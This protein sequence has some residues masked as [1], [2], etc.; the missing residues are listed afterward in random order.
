MIALNGSRAGPNTC[1]SIQ[2][3]EYSH[4]TSKL[5]L[6]LR[7]FQRMVFLA[8]AIFYILVLLSS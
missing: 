1:V 5:H 7:F 4:S 2:N 3:F 8:K 6:A